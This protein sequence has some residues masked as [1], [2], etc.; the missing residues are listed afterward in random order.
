TKA[1]PDLDA[2][3]KKTVSIATLLD[4][5]APKDFVT[6]ASPKTLY[7]GTLT[8]FGVL[9]GQPHNNVHNC[10]GGMSTQQNSGGFMQANLSPVDPIFWLHHSN[11]DRIWDVWTRKQ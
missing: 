2:N 7:H 10:I 4:S 9:E 5:L 1:Q 8:G 11:V 6:F 3:T